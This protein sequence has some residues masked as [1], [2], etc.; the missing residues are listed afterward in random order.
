MMPE[1]LKQAPTPSRETREEVKRTVEEMLE[2]IEAEGEEAIRDYSRRLDRWDPPSF[3]VGEG[4]IAAAAGALT[5]EL[6]GH[7]AF[8]QDQVR[9]FATR[10]R[11]TLGP[12][13]V[14]TLPG[15]RPVGVL[16][17]RRA[18]P[19][20][21]LGVH[22]RAR[23]QGGGRRACR[24]VR[25]AVAEP[26]DPPRNAACDGH[27]WRRRDHLPGRGASPRCARVRT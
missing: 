19:D 15:V 18:L 11:E 22:D 3:R 5:E 23:P 1:Y 27:L 8:A 9:T 7:I 25:A 4:E 10:Q 20:A 24:R 2:R 14:E 13:E 6:R 21:C 12:P 16:R 26:R 17:A